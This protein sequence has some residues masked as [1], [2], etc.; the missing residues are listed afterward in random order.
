MSLNLWIDR[1]KREATGYIGEGLKQHLSCVRGNSEKP[2]DPFEISES[3]VQGK[4]INSEACSRKQSY[5]H[6]LKK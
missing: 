5:V 3:M 4:Q 6:L 1:D 2:N